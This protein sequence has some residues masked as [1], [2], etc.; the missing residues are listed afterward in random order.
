MKRKM[1]S[2]AL[3]RT[4]EIKE[5]DCVSIGKSEELYF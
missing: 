2:E 1:K 3:K 4:G 5:G